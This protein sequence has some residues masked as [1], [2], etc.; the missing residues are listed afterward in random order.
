[1]VGQVGQKNSTNTRMDTALLCIKNEEQPKLGVRYSN[2]RGI[3]GSQ[4][5]K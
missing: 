2:S 4:E 1:M 5:N 3:G